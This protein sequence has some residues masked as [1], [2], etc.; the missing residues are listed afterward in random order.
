MPDFRRAVAA[1]GMAFHLMGNGRVALRKGDAGDAA[2]G[3]A[4]MRECAGR[5]DGYTHRLHRKRAVGRHRASPENIS[6]EA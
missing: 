4:G 2:V 1:F 6:E 5:R 3:N